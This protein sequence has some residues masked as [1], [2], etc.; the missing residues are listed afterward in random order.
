MWAPGNLTQAINPWSWMFQTDNTSNNSL[1]TVNNSYKG[2]PEVEA[3]VTAE[4]AGY[5]KQLGKTAEVVSILLN[6]MTPAQKAAL[7]PTEKAEIASYNKMIDDIEAKKRDMLLSKFSPGGLSSLIGALEE[8]K[9]EEPK[10]F[11]EV[12]TALKKALG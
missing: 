6:S 11:K 7:S 2:D 8:L 10:E 5:G 9:R 12:S 3:A 1:I 4:V